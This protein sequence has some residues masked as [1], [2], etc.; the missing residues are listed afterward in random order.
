MEPEAI[1]TDRELGLIK[2]LGVIFP[3]VQHLPCWVHVLRC[4]EDKAFD[5][6]KDLGIKGRFKSDCRGLFMS[7]SEETYIRRR[8]IMFARWPALMSYVDK[9]W[10]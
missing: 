9:V 2:A 1:V 3:H 5:I 7:L 8:R 4:C 10:L 6:T